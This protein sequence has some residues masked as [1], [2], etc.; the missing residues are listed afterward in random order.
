MD[1]SNIAFDGQGLH[2]SSLLV[3]M[4]AILHW[5]SWSIIGWATLKATSLFRPHLCKFHRV[6]TNPCFGIQCLQ[7]V[8]TNFIRFS[9]VRAITTLATQLGEFTE[10]LAVKECE[11]CPKHRWWCPRSILLFSLCHSHH[12][13]L[14]TLQPRN[15]HCHLPKQCHCP[16]IPQK[17]KTH[18]WKS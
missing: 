14:R 2:I 15:W 12:S 8:Q 1:E 7:H 18:A 9:P 13:Y 3:E 16:I 17:K 6:D 5:H 4:V 11:C 10:V